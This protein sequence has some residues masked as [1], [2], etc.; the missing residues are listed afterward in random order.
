MKVEEDIMTS[1]R[2]LAFQ[3]LLGDGMKPVD[4]RGPLRESQCTSSLTER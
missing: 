4:H 1:V 2:A 3:Y